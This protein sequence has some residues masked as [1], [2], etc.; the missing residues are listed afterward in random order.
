MEPLAQSREHGRLMPRRLRYAMIG[1]GPSS[2]IGPVHRIAAR[3]DDRW[4][5]VAGAFSSDPARSA[6]AGVECHIAPE[7]AYP[8]WQAM[9]ATEAA[10]AADDRID[11]VAIVT[12]NHL[13]AA[14]AIAALEA[15][16][17]VI[18]DKPL[19]TSV[20]EGHRIAEAVSR[21]GRQFVLT[22][23]YAG[24]PMVREMR[25]LVRSGALGT[26]R[27]IRAEYAQD[28]L[29]QPLEREGN[30]QA[31][32]RSDPHRSGPAGALGDIGTHAFH[33]ATFVTGLEAEAMCADLSS[34]GAGRQLDDNAHI[35]LRYPNG[36]RG[37]LWAS[38]VAPGRGNRLWLGVYGSEGGVEWSQEEPNT[39]RFTRI[40]E[41]PQ[42]IER[43]S[44]A[45]TAGNYLTRAPGGHPEGWLEAFAQIYTDAADLILASPQDRTASLAPQIEAG[46]EGMA[47]ISG[48]LKSNARQGWLAREEWAESR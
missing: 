36:V 39:L 2:F 25:R 17:H 9:I 15:G 8:G 27:I 28:W 14:P 11:A 45:C 19:A 32:W 4:E 35:L 22:H 6:R 13:H 41:A 16:F 46:L 48:A 1:G 5:L 12:P 43:G 18:C 24:Y 42:M 33:L 23:V 29:T 31:E 47:F 37:T 44:L 38:Q 10:R 21:S 40:G 34:F 3:I 26:I 7:R 20:D 30:K